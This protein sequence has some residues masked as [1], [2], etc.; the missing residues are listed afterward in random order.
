MIPSGT[1]AGKAIVDA[2]DGRRCPVEGIVADGSVGEDEAV[3]GTAV[4]TAVAEAVVA[5]AA[6]VAGDF[7]AGSAAAED[8]W[9]SVV[10]GGPIG[11]RDRVLGLVP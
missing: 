3:V 6:A 11:S 8:S 2:G 9:W 5:A 10:A 1:A 7:Q 4:A